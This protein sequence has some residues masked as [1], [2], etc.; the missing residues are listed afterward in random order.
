MRKKA[1]NQIYALIQTVH[2]IEQQLGPDPQLRH[3]H[4]ELREA[5]RRLHEALSN[6]CKGSSR[7]V[8]AA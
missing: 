3:A 6:L 7:K 1:V 4:D 2:E 8:D 5:R